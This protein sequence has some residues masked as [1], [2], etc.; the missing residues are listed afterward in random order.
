M[1]C[2]FDWTCFRTVAVL[3][4]LMG[5][6]M[7][8][9]EGI[10]AGISL[11]E[12]PAHALLKR[13]KDRRGEKFIKGYCGLNDE[14]VFFFLFAS[15]VWQTLFSPQPFSILV[16]STHPCIFIN[17]DLPIFFLLFYRFNFLQ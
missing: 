16:C 10:E 7:V 14:H 17:D 13:E 3:R 6:A 2:I 11:A 4:S 15:L 12:P 5:G 9:G 1:I 8:D